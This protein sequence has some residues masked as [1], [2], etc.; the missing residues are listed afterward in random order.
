MGRLQR[1]GRWFFEGLSVR[2]LARRVGKP[3][4]ACRKQMARALKKLSA[5]LNYNY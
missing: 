5:L 1:I 3:E 4:A 2:D